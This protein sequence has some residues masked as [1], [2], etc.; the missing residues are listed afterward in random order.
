MLTGFRL[1]AEEIG[2]LILHPV[3]RVPIGT[4][5]VRQ[6]FAHELRAGRATLNAKVAESLYNIATKGKG[7]PAVTAAVFWLKANARWTEEAP[8]AAQAPG[9]LVV[10]AVLTVDQWVAAQRAENDKKRPPG[11]R[12]AEPTAGPGTVAG[13]GGAKK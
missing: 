4:A 11:S 10:P 1:S 12:K 5:A 8:E 13:G 9:V 6:L 3:T 7:S 2:T